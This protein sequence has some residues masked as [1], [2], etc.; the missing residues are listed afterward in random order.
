M[1]K[2]TVYRCLA[3]L[4]TNPEILL[5]LFFTV[6][7]HRDTTPLVICADGVGEAAPGCPDRGKI[8]L[9]YLKALTEVSPQSPSWLIPLLALLGSDKPATLHTVFRDSDIRTII[10]ELPDT[11][12]GNP[13]PTSIVLFFSGDFPA[14]CGVTTL[15]TPARQFPTT[16]GRIA[17]WERPI[18]WC[19]GASPLEI[20]NVAL[21]RAWRAKLD[22]Q[23]ARLST[24]QSLIG[25][26]LYNIMY[27]I[28]HAL[29]VTTQ[30]L[31]ADIGQ[32]YAQ[33]HLHREG[34]LHPVTAMIHAL[35]SPSMWD[36]YLTQAASRALTRKSR[37]PVMAVDPA[38]VWTW[39]LSLA[40]QA[41]F[42][43]LL[44]LH[45]VPW[46]VSDIRPTTAGPPNGPA[47]LWTAYLLF[48]DAALTGDRE[49]ARVYGD[50]TEDMWR[51][52]LAMTRPV[53]RDVKCALPRG[54]APSF[55]N[56]VVGYGPASHVTFC[57]MSRWIEAVDDANPDWRDA[58]IS[59]AKYVAGIYLE[60][61]MKRARSDYP[62]F[63]LGAM[64][65]RRRAVAL[66]ERMVERFLIRTRLETDFAPACRAETATNRA[67]KDVPLS[68]RAPMTASTPAMIAWCR[69]AAFAA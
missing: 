23:D 58:G 61:G 29:S 50:L 34:I 17:T 30:A 15:P 43:M 51:M 66:L 54:S 26:P 25:V 11:L 9:M 69:T 7:A 52:M 14:C 48:V 1:Q 57:G 64:A 5:E 37:K 20:Y 22:E 68:L 65:K 24:I 55:Y 35:F 8:Y 60:H 12:Y 42:I 47:A 21:G 59:Y 38:I 28:V 19:C 13:N 16:A 3:A 27:E 41:L 62:D 63:G 31:L 67:Y 40:Q 56:P 44:T 49:G 33:V 36:P 18:C 53:P 45:A 6:Y 32:Y 4:V 46:D 39:L 10:G 2:V